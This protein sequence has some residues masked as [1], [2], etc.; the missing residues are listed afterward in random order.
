MAH[1]LD[2]HR[3]PY[4]HC[5]GALDKCTGCVHLPSMMVIPSGIVEAGLWA[6]AQT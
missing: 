6:S 3:A 4:V 2:T 5:P 1:T